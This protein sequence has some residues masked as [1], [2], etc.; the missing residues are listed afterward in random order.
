VGRNGR[1]HGQTNRQRCPSFASTTA[2]GR[3]LRKGQEITRTFKDPNPI[4]CQREENI[5]AEASLIGR[6]PN[7]ENRWEGSSKDVVGGG[8][9]RKRTR[10]RRNEVRR[11]KD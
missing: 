1:E 9:N 8:H 3:T 2:A 7:G 5:L 10:K 6:E 11:E 4:E